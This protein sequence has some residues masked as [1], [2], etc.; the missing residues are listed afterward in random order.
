MTYRVLRTV[1][2]AP[3]KWLHGAQMFVALPLCVVGLIA[4]F[5]FHNAKNIPN[6]YSLHSWLGLIAVILFFSQVNDFTLLSMFFTSK[7]R[8]MRIPVIHRY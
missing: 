4:V 2:K 8:F 5:D 6:M 7:F 3:L 1:R